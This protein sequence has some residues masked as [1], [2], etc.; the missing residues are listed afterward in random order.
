M[1]QSLLTELL[2]YHFFENYSVE[3]EQLTERI[4]IK[5]D[6]LFHCLQL[7]CLLLSVLVV[8]LPEEDKH[9][10]QGIESL[11]AEVLP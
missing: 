6:S 2:A 5:V 9:C 7:L 1:S 10:V 4:L 8:L 3:H 11:A